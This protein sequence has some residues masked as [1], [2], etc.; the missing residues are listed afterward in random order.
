MSCATI[1]TPAYAMDATSFLLSAPTIV[2]EE[3]SA[4]LHA[5]H[6]PLYYQAQAQHPFVS[7]P[8]QPQANW[9]MAGSLDTSKDILHQS[10]QPRLRIAHA[11]KKCQLRK[12]KCTG[13]ST[14]ARCARRG[15]VCEYAPQQRTRGPNKPKHHSASPSR[16]TSSL[17]S[18]GSTPEMDIIP[19]VIR[20]H[21]S[22]QAKRTPEPKVAVEEPAHDV[23]L[24]NMFPPAP[25]DDLDWMWTELFG[26]TNAL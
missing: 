1:A 23:N 19:A 7:Y 14:C 2:L 16:S 5:Q 3:L 22:S 9:T 13:E 20:N 26:S 4:Y 21:Y 24:Q 6:L 10:T 12:V 15:F 8:T 18:R 11:C 17:S 25:S